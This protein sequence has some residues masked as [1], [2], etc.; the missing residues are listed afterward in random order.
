MKVLL[1]GATGYVGH[2]LALTLARNNYT[3]HALVR[4]MNSSKVPQH[5]NIRLF[6]GNV[7]DFN[8]IMMAIDTCEYVFHTAAYT[9]LRCTNVDDFY[10]TNV[11]GTENILKAAMQS[12]IKKV[13]YTSTLSVYGPSYKNV[14]I[15]E[16]QPRLSSFSNDYELTKSMSEEIIMDYST[17]GMPCIV[18]NVSKVYGPGLE[19]FSSGVN[20]LISMMIKKNILFI[21]N[22]L[23]VKSNYVYIDDVVNAHILAMENQSV[24]GKYIIGGE[25]SNYKN[26]FK[27]IKTLTKSKIIIVKINYNF[28]KMAVSFLNIVRYLMGYQPIVTSRVLDSLFVNRIA[29]SEKAIIDLNYTPSSLDVGLSNTIKFLNHQT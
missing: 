25:N 27:R 21:P 12:N 8:S 10:L 15:N 23:K 28:F 11:L 14:P 26:L 9:D 6:E 4:D 20:K 13:I 2:Q 1:T 17:K 24:Q 7:C 3:V 22:I 19:T 29:T 16:R 5:N 18:L